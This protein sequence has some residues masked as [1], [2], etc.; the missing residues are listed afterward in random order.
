M[1]RGGILQIISFFLYVFIQVFFLKNAVLFHTAFCFL[2]VAYL[3][4]LPVETNP[5]ALMAIG[6]LMGFIIDIFYDSLGLHAIANVF[7]MY[8]RNYW[9]NNI[10]PQGGYDNNSVPALAANG[11][12]WYLVYIIPL[13]FV[14]HALLFFIE[15]AGF[16]MFWFTLWKAI[17]STLF[18][19][20]VIIIVKFLFPDR[21]RR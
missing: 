9:L 16:G 17:A 2:Y 19:S 7:I 5:L 15:A 14:H 12:Q 20:L 6:F 18:T 1:T 21:A 4:S 13:V 3:L 8:M 10:T 11:L